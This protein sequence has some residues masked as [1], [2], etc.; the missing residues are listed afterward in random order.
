MFSKMITCHV[1]KAEIRAGE[2]MAVIAEYPM[3]EYVGNTN[4]I[5]R[6]WIQ[7]TGG[8]VYCHTCFQKRD[9]A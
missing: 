3:C 7:T 8:K 2:F 1:C 4:S 9:N 6:K 5:L